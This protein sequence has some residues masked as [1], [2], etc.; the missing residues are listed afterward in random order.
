MTL[1]IVSL[2]SGFG[3]FV[4]FLSRQRVA[5]QK[6]MEEIGRQIVDAQ[7]RMPALEFLQR[8]VNNLRE[9]M[10]KSL[11]ESARLVSD[12]QKTVGERL[13]RAADVV[14]KVQK[15]LGSLDQAT[16]QVFAVGKD[17]STLQEILR[18]PKMRGAIG[19]LFLG[20]LLGQILPPKHF[21]L[22]HA[23]RSG[24]IVDAVVKLGKLVPIDAKFPL[25]NF[26]R[27]LQSQDPQE[28]TQARRQFVNDVKKHIDAIS[29]KYLLPHEGTYDFALM[30][31]PTESVYYE[32]IIKDDNLVD[33][34]SV[35]TYA[36]S[37]RVVPV[38]PNSLYAYL[39]T[40]SLGLRGL[41]I[42]ENARHIIEQLDRLKN[43]FEKFKEDFFMVGK[44]LSN[45]RTKYEDAERRLVRFEDKL[46]SSAQGQEK[47][48]LAETEP[49]PTLPLK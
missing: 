36:F 10:T 40:I 39:H 21:S 37:K 19:E 13:D 3:V 16:Q 43:D 5:S 18:A 4:W 22:Q 17:I 11:A 38:S 15:S 25:E 23:F 2:A 45:S 35:M 26:K 8:E 1:L 24:V 31:I 46:L 44:H 48:A 14:G 49:L 32:V 6:Q 28:K 30:Y 41:Q 7:S 27:L 34:G 29:S 20:D 42:E 12:S 47:K 9:Q 33:D